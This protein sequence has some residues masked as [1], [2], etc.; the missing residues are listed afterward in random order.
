MATI[1]SASTQKITAKLYAR[2]Q[3]F[4]IT[5]T[6]SNYFFMKRTDDSQIN[7]IV[8]EV[9]INKGFLLLQTTR[10]YQY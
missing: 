7:V 10:D 8:D 9:S 5:P 3:G 1:L 6:I 2:G 4:E